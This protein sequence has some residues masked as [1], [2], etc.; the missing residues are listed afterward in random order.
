MSANMKPVLRVLVLLAMTSRVG[1][2]VTISATNRYAYAA[3]VG[4]VDWHGDGTSGVV[5]AEFVCAG[6]MYSANCGWIAM[7]A[8]APTNGV[9]YG[10]LATNDY[11]V[12]VGPDGALRGYAYGANVG[13]I[14]FESNGNPRVDYGSGCL[15]GYVYG[16][17]VGWISLSNAFACVQ[18][19]ARA[20]EL[21]VDGD[22]LPDAWERARVGQLE[23]LMGDGAD[24]DGDG[25]LDEQEYVA[26]TDP[27][28]ARDYPR[29]TM[30][31]AVGGGPFALTWRSDPGRLYV[32]EACADQLE[33]AAWMPV[34]ETP[35][36]ADAGGF[37]TRML[38]PVAEPRGAMRMRV[39]L[40]F[41]R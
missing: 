18:T 7:G 23:M 27:A 20:V 3:N 21:D 22:G 9:R 1:A 11:G 40:P 28:D 17:N 26:N 41:S 5:V 8:G 2:A 37:S 25:V 12:N 30:L 35:W 29:I 34:D 16:A 36:R 19:V 14:A 10:N 24:Y 6:F 15:S 31:T 38:V 39:L 32:L 13:W 33:A 4:W